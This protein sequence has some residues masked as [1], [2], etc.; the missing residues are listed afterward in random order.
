M[1]YNFVYIHTQITRCAPTLNVSYAQLHTS[2]PYIR[3]GYHATYQLPPLNNEEALLDFV[4][5]HFHLFP[6]S[7]SRCT[8]T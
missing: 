8:Y 5:I 4:T 6:S 2:H 1:L 3:H 7:R